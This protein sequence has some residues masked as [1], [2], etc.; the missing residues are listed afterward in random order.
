MP[1]IA[2]IE[3]DARIGN[4]GM[5]P[6]VLYGLVQCILRITIVNSLTFDT[7]LLSQIVQTAETKL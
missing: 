6:S 1:I 3:C 7:V 4:A 2:T 5:H